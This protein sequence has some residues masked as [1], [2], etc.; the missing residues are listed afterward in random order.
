[1]I[2]YQTGVPDFLMLM[3]SLVPDASFA[4]SRLKARPELD[5]LVCAVRC[6]VGAKLYQ[7]SRRLRRAEEAVAF[8]A[9]DASAVLVRTSS[10][11]T[12]QRS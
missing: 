5:H 1:M 7:A 3:W 12:S 2:T 8:A 6:N 10:S 9:Q 11:L 4:N